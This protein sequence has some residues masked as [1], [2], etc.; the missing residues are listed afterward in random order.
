MVSLK[1]IPQLFT[2]VEKR[3]R[4]EHIS[5][6]LFLF[7]SSIVLLFLP[8]CICNSITN[9]VLSHY[10]LFVPLLILTSHFFSLLISPFFFT[11]FL[12]FLSCPSLS[13]QFV[14]WISHTLKKS[15]SVG[16]ILSWFNSK[17]YKQSSVITLNYLITR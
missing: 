13:F 2:E 3:L 6:L 8:S 9:K 4:Y 5:S 1:L 17:M 7:I 11:L 15:H 12:L 16:V 14:L 10:S